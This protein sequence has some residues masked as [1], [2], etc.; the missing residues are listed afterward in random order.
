[1]NEPNQLDI[2]VEILKMEDEVALNHAVAA[3]V[4]T[5]MPYPTDNDPED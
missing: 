2:E 4:L 3:Y 5:P 1:M